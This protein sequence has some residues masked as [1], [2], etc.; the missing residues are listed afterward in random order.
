MAAATA[1]PRRIRRRAVEAVVDRLQ[2][3]L[4]EGL[5]AGRKRI[6]RWIAALG[7][8][9]VELV[10]EGGTALCLAEQADEIRGAEP[11]DQVVF[12]PGSD[13]WVLG[14]GTSDEHVVPPYTDRS[15]PA[16]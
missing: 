4:G 15:R 6:T 13:Q 16:V 2:Y 5:S 3:W 1:P 11:S 14:A 8:E 9:L 7:K 10:F 12:L